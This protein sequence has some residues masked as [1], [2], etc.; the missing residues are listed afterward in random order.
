M[1]DMSIRGAG[2]PA[3]GRSTPDASRDQDAEAVVDR[4]RS[5]GV[6]MHALALTNLRSVGFADLRAHQRPGHHHVGGGRVPVDAGEPG[7]RA[8]ARQGPERLRRPAVQGV[9]DLRHGRATTTH[10]DGADQPV[11]GHLSSSGA[12]RAAGGD[13]GT[14]RPAAGDGAGHAGALLHSRPPRC[15]S[16]VG[17]S[18]ARP[19][20]IIR[21]L[22]GDSLPA[23]SARPFRCRWPR[24]DRPGGCVRIVPAPGHIWMPARQMNARRLRRRTA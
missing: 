12:R 9:V 18:A 7:A 11:P 13:P 22:A 8:H 2:L 19:S 5:Y 15:S 20:I 14:G 23:R 4:L 10:R 21:P 3:R 6:V 16:S 1:Q 24:S 17:S